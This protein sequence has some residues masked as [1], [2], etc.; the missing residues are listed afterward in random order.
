MHPSRLS[1]QGHFGFGELFCHF[2]AAPSYIDCRFRATLDQILK[3]RSVFAMT[4]FEEGETLCEERNIF[5]ETGKLG[6]GKMTECWYLRFG[7]PGRLALSH[8]RSP[9]ILIVH[10]SS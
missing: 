10:R 4:A 8:P 1:C 6:S 3:P 7:A 9:V 5:D 2:R